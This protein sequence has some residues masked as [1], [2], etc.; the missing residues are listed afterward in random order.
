[1]N[2]VGPVFD[3]LCWWYWVLSSDNVFSIQTSKTVLPDNGGLPVSP[4]F[5]IK[6]ATF[7]ATFFQHAKMWPNR[8]FLFPGRKW[9]K[10]PLLWHVVNSGNTDHKCQC[11]L[12]TTL[13]KFELTL[14]LLVVFCDKRSTS[15]GST[16]DRLGC[17]F[18]IIIRLSDLIFTQ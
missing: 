14:K 6:I 16:W 3:T 8:L 12:Q 18:E 5:P 17:L 13:W 1:M 11:L 15:K 10:S 2:F 9:E 7:V 4:T